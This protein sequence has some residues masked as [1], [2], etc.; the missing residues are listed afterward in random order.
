MVG[1]Q[2]ATRGYVRT[3]KLRGFAPMLHKQ[4]VQF[5]PDHAVPCF[6]PTTTANHRSWC[7][8][9]NEQTSAFSVGKVLIY[10]STTTSSS[11][12]VA[13]VV[14]V[15]VVVF[16]RPS[17]DL[18]LSGGSVGPRRGAGRALVRRL[19]RVRAVGACAAML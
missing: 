18:I 13:V 3:Q 7:S 9:Q 8:L 15:V 2:V 17:V 14:V 10:S 12:L 1:T 11:R 16:V 4:E 19:G 6:A 5:Y